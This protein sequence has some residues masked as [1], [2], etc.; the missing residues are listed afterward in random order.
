M[1]CPAHSTMVHG[2]PSYLLLIAKATSRVSQY[3][4][5]YYGAINCALNILWKNAVLVPLTE[6]TLAPVKLSLH[7]RIILLVISFC[8]EIH[9]NRGFM[10]FEN[11]KLG[12]SLQLASLEVNW[13]GPSV[14]KLLHNVGDLEW[15]SLTPFTLAAMLGLTWSTCFSNW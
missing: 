15:T 12:K 14:Y 13:F 10:L 2:R 6:H 9:A 8:A 1:A 11:R 4:L 7:R 5:R 3:F